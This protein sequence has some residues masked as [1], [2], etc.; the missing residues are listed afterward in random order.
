MLINTNPIEPKIVVEYEFQFGNG[1]A[2]AWVI[3]P[4]AGDSVDWDTSPL[5]V[6]FRLS[7]KPHP[8]DP[9]TKFP[10][11]ETTIFLNQVL[12]ITKR[13]RSVIPPSP[14]EQAAWQTTLHEL[15]KTVQ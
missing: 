12:F 3:D 1:A 7:E 6:T 10:A 2:S 5:A 13:Q 8:A 4:L 11:E 15:I 14:E 9:N